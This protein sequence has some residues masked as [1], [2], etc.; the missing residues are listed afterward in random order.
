MAPAQ[1]TCPER[2]RLLDEFK[3][4][5]GALSRIHDAEIS[6]IT[7]GDEA[8]FGRLQA[9][10]QSAREYR[11]VIVDSLMQHRREHGC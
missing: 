4:A 5:C 8:A 11:A 2:Q 3:K 1:E 9:D 7:G 6:A 10:L